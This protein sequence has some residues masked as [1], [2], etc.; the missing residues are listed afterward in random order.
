MFPV[1]DVKVIRLNP[2]VA[3]PTYSTD[4]AAAVDLQSALSV[5]VTIEP[6]AKAVLI[7]TGL[8]I[9]HGNKHF[10]EF[11]LPRSGLGHKKGLVLG[12]LVGVIDSDYQGEL[13]V[14]A[15]IHPGYEPYT[16]QP[17]ERFAQLVFL[18]I[19]LASFSEVSE[20]QIVTDRA[21]GGFGSTGSH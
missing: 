2:D 17:L 8:K 19:A 18:P 7:P 15:Y 5:P 16:I 11:I 14:S 3:L 6:G 10:G 21:E 9:Y 12:N 1:I 20:F 13:M 4:G